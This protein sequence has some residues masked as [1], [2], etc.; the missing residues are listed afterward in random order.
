VKLKILI[1]VLV[2]LIVVNLATIGSYIYFRVQHEQAEF[3]GEFPGRFSRPP[4]LD[5][6]QKQRQQLLDL[7][8][9]FQKDTREISEEIRKTR[10]EI[11]Q[12]LKQDSVPMAT[13][14]EKLRKTAN[15][16]MQIE[17]IAIKKL[18]EARHYLSPQQMDHLYRFL[19]M[20]PPQHMG[21]DFRRRPGFLRDRDQ[22]KNFN[23]KK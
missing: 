19:L 3:V 13:V 22:I 20:E 8:M 15:L 23:N 1:G 16:R 14:E 21:P 18:V 9:S 7:R 17:K 11:Y 10:G 5:L 12:I 2:F 4:D 6:D